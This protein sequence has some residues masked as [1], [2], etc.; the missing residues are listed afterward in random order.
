MQSKRVLDETKIDLGRKTDVA[1]GSTRSDVGKVTYISCV[2]VAK[3]GV[4]VGLGEG[5]AGDASPSFD[6]SELSPFS[7]WGEGDSF[8]IWGSGVPPVVTVDVSLVTEGLGSRFSAIVG[9]T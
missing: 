8:E 6:S 9:I 1:R 5:V 3:G 4:G 2:P 7:S